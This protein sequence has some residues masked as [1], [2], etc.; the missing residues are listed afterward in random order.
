LGQNNV[1]GTC[2]RLELKW[3][4][5]SDLNKLSHQRSCTI[6]HPEHFSQLYQKLCDSLVSLGAKQTFVATIPHLTIVPLIRGVSPR[7][8]ARGTDELYKGYYE[9][10]TRF[11]IWDEAFDPD[12]HQHLTRE[13]A[14]LIDATIDE[15][16]RIIR[17]LAKAHGFLVI[18]LAS[19]LDQ[20]AF[21]RQKGRPSY[22]FPPGLVQALKQNPATAFRVRPD[23]TVLLDTR[24]LTIPEQPP[25][26][27][28]P[29]EVW[30]RAYKGGLFGLDGAHPTTVGYGLVAHAV[31]ATL[32]AA[33]V[34]G[35]DPNA[36]PW[37]DIVRSD[38]L[39]RN[40]P[41]ILTSLQ[42]TLGTIFSS[43]PIAKAI[44]KIGGYAAEAKPG[45]G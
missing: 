19:I 4:Q 7:A 12:V 15:Y 37:D 38:L 29:S 21:R 34:A 28:D 16:N 9:Y 5:S 43:R 18:D 2:V 36:L 25:R 11:W 3:S 20:L 10:Y 27:S 45:R 33:G 31:L 39:L 1:L 35:A 14:I 26:D 8:R 17:K 32:R 40:P 13:D 30:Q 23:G 22:V 44:E 6:W 41:A 42:Q 24:Y